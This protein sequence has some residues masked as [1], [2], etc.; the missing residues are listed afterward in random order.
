VEPKKNYAG[1]LASGQGG[2]LTEIEVKGEDRPAFSSGLL[3]NGTVGE[4]L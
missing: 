4:P 1:L 3:E 2:N